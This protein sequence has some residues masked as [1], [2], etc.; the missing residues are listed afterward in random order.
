MNNSISEHSHFEELCSLAAVGQITPTE[1]EAL[2]DHMRGCAQCQDAHAEFYNLVHAQLPLLAAQEAQVPKPTGLLAG[3]A[4]KS[5]K[6]R[7]IAHAKE[8]GIEFSQPASPKLRA[9]SLPAA[10]AKLQPSYRLVSVMAV[11][12]LLV[13]GGFL[14][15]QLGQTR[16]H[17]TLLAA[18]VADLSG[19]NQGLKIQAEQL[20]QGKLDVESHLINTNVNR[21]ELDTRLGD[22]ERQLTAANLTMEKLETLVKDSDTRAVQTQQELASAKQSLVTVNQQFAQ[23][24]AARANDEAGSVAQ[25]VN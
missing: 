9:L 25:K 14:L 23:F 1:Y 16:Q 24:R 11:S 20:L 21:K 4:D 12:A 6:A 22:L 19:R 3:I 15:H 10:L 8:H 13:S 18:Q 7:F 2:S 5:Y 17:E